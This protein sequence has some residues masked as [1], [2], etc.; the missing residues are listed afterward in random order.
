MSH[1]TVDISYVIQFSTVHNY[2]IIIT[3]QLPGEECTSPFQVFLHSFRFQKFKHFQIHF[4]HFQMCSVLLVCAYLYL[5]L[6]FPVHRSLIYDFWCCNSLRPIPVLRMCLKA[7]NVVTFPKC[8]LMHPGF[9]LV[10]SIK[11]G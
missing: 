8:V 7:A 3:V 11:C 1:S 9:I 2:I 5:F 6:P 10:S 4:L